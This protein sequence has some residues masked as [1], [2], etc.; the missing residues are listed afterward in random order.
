MSPNYM[1]VFD[2]I[3]A[4][5]SVSLALS[6]LHHG[7]KHTTHYDAAVHHH[8]P[9]CRRSTPQPAKCKP[10]CHN[11]LASCLDQF[12]GRKKIRRKL[13][14]SARPRRMWMCKRTNCP[15][16]TRIH[17]Y[18]GTVLRTRASHPGTKLHCHRGT[19][20]RAA[21]RPS[22]TLSRRPTSCVHAKSMRRSTRKSRQPV[23]E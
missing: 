3:R 15:H 17:R 12:P 18:L 22:H 13:L 21:E 10:L 9:R 19:R 23:A 8:S 6:S 5:R 14:G 4:G 11:K 7:Q 16:A 1:P 2:G 20:C